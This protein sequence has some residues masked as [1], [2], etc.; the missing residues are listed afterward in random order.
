[1]MP[2]ESS[3][4]D[5]LKFEAQQVLDDLLRR[6]LIPF[7]LTAFKVEWIGLDKYVIYFHDS[8]LPSIIV[9]WVQGESF[10]DEFRAAILDHVSRMS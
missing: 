8:R 5:T 2:A 7:P 9:S 1:M 6:D 3:A 10:R 4:A